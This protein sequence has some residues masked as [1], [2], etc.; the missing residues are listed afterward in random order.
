[1]LLLF[2]FFEIAAATAA[3]YAPRAAAKT[4][5]FVLLFMG[6][7]ALGGDDQDGMA[8]CLS[9]CTN[10]NLVFIGWFLFATLK[11]PLVNL[12]QSGG[13]AE[14]IRAL[15]GWASHGC[16]FCTSLAFSA[17]AQYTT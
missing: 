11:D 10:T 9:G 17:Y 7:W 5:F 6:R 2:L 16:R 3:A 15:V 8:V 12:F 1:M 4:A 14:I 13:M